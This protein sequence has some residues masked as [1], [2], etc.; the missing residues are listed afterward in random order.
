MSNIRER[1][2]DILTYRGAVCNQKGSP[3]LHWINIDLLT[4]PILTNDSDLPGLDKL[5]SSEKSLQPCAKKIYI[6]AWS[7]FLLCNFILSYSW[8]AF[9]SSISQILIVSSHLLHGLQLQVLF[10]IPKLLSLP[11][12]QVIPK[13]WVDVG[14]ISRVQPSLTHPIEQSINQVPKQHVE[15][16][17]HQRV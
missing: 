12:C 8:I 5:T 1:E 16:F 15:D 4:L 9:S 17:R 6:F 11:N 2:T 10:H 13:V 14:K 7:T 3:R